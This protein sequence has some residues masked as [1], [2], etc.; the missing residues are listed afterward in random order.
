MQLYM[1]KNDNVH[2]VMFFNEGKKK[3]H[4]CG[5]KESSTSG[6]SDIGN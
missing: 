2:D 4:G 6:C 1:D 3:S 5:V